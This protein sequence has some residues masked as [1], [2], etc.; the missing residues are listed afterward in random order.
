MSVTLC[1][2]GTVEFRERNIMMEPNFS[3][4]YGTINSVSMYGKTAV[5]NDVKAEEE[6]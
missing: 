1:L 4:P 6:R 2:V 3:Q 5:R